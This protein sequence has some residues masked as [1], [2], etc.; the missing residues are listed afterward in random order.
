MMS[1]KARMAVHR[2][3]LENLACLLLGQ[4]RTLNTVRVVRKLYLR[5]VVGI[6]LKPNPLLPTVLFQQI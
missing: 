3:H 4:L 1:S 6:P 5:L 2:S